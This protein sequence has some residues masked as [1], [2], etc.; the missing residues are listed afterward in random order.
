MEDEYSVDCLPGDLEELELEVGVDT[1]D[2]CVSIHDNGGCDE[3][4]DHGR[5]GE[6]NRRRSRLDREYELERAASSGSS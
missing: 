2:K 3:T 6:G 1:E 4:S 5:G